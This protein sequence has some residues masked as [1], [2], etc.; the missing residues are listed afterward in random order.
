MLEESSINVRHC[1]YC[2]DD[3]WRELKSRLAREGA[4]I[5]SWFRQQ[6]EAKIQEDNTDVGRSYDWE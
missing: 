6:A 5:S 1:V 3:T 4:S 2:P